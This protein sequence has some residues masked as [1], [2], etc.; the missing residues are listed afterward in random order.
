[1]KVT[2]G[3]IG[4]GACAIL[5]GNE[6]SLLSVPGNTEYANETAVLTQNTGKNLC[7]SLLDLQMLFFLQP[8]DAREH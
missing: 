6:V 7:G 5:S 4:D 2:C 3:H 8:T 1:V